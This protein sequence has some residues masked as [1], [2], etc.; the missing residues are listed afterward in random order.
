M[1]VPVFVGLLAH[2]KNEIPLWLLN[3]RVA[4]GCALINYP[5]ANL[6]KLSTY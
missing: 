5:I 3:R 1:K 6:L 2:P 4:H